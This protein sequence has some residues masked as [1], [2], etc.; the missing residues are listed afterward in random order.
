MHNDAAYK[1]FVYWGWQSNQWLKQ[2][3]KLNTNEGS[4]NTTLRACGMIESK[5]FVS[6]GGGLLNNTKQLTVYETYR[7]AKETYIVMYC[8]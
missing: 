3:M 5:T 2:A 8:L 4:L 6:L 7:C 1:L